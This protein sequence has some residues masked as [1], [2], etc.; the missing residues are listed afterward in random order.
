MDSFAQTLEEIKQLKLTILQSELNY[1]TALQNFRGLMQQLNLKRIKQ[2]QQGNQQYYNPCNPESYRILGSCQ[3]Q[4]DVGKI[5]LKLIKNNQK[6]NFLAQKT[7]DSLVEYINLRFKRLA[8]LHQPMPLSKSAMSY[9]DQEGTVSLTSDHEG[10]T[11][12]IKQDPSL[13]QDPPPTIANSPI[14]TS[15]TASLEQ[16]VKANAD[17]VKVDPS[18]MPISALALSEVCIKIETDLAKNKQEQLHYLNVGMSGGPDSTLVLILAVFLA[19][20]YPHLYQAQA[21]HCIHG[22]DPDDQIWL[23]HNQRLCEQ[24]RVK[25]H[26]PILNIVYGDG[27]SPEDSS[28]QERYK[29]LFSYCRPNQDFLMLGH[30]ADDQIEGF[31]L[32]L[33]RG[34]GPKG[35][36]GMSFESVTPQALIIR[37]ILDLHK[38]EVEQLLVCLNF[39]YV[40]DL[41]NNYM[42]FDRNFMRLKVL[43]VI[44]QRFKGIDRAVL[45]SQELCGMEHELAQRYA[46]DQVLK[47]V[48]GVDY[49]PYQAFNFKALD[50]SDRPLVFMLLKTWIEQCTEQS[51]EFNILEQ[52]YALMLKEHDRN[53]LLKLGISSKDHKEYVASRFLNSLCIYQP[54]D[55]ANQECF[56]GKHPFKFKLDVLERLLQ[57]EKISELTVVSEVLDFAQLHYVLYV[58]P[59]YVIKV[60]VTDF[61][62]IRQESL[63]KKFG[64]KASLDFGKLRRRLVNTMFTLS[65]FELESL[66]HEPNLILDFDYTQSLKLKARLRRHSREIKKLFVEYEV[67][68]FLRYRQ[69]LVKFKEQIL[70]LGDICAL[71]NG[72]GQDFK[73]LEESN[74]VE[75]PYYFVLEIYQ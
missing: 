71:G 48:Y 19:Q 26:T 50:L 32:A 42:K 46:Q 57:H 15:I 28:R 41:S 52:L 22:L 10:N 30:Q 56:V 68:P 2:E 64:A 49:A 63:A 33:K 54:A 65:S 74:A 73:Y 23:V 61:K 14:F 9:L 37:P 4:L 27:V 25:L 21:I 20:K 8:M 59:N 18:S 17:Q 29:A 60:E 47:Y 36:S 40:F 13:A 58:V 1:K 62:Q 16:T 44:R 43:P 45:R 75:E 12:T 51:V 3:D 31:L 7:V 35:L 5:D 11:P 39:D 66:K 72:V 69:P 70:A 55:L 38:I 34:A 67:E 24:L 6:L 53:G